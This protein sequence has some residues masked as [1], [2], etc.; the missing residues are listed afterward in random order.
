MIRFLPRSRAL[1]L[2]DTMLWPALESY[3]RT[4]RLVGPSLDASVWFHAPSRAEQ[5]LLIEAAAVD[6]VASMQAIENPP[7]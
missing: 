1:L 6:P 5:W 3:G 7:F 4:P 2:I